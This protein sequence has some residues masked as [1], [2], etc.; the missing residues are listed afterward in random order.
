M[1]KDHSPGGFNRPS[2]YKSDLEVAETGHLVKSVNTSFGSQ[3]HNSYIM[4]CDH[5]HEHFYYDPRTLRCGWHGSKFE[6]RNNHPQNQGGNIKSTN[7]EDT[8]KKNSFLESLKVDQATIDRC[9]EVSQNA[10]KAY[11]QS[12]K[13]A[14]DDGGRERGDNGPGSLG[15]EPG[16]KS[17][18]CE[19]SKSSGQE[20]AGQGS[21]SG[22]GSGGQETGG[23]HGS[24]GQGGG[25][26][27][28]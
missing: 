20:S 28:D 6:T 18:E 13:T 22:K 10:A 2:G 7:G 17:G 1:S 25:H 19:G 12:T 27:Y 9:N 26:G 21:E 5:T 4:R 15:R 23:G 16:N 8:V 14:G 11:T 24:E 3:N